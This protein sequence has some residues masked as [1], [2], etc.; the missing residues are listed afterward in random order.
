M[1]EGGLYEFHK[2]LGGTL[3]SFLKILIHMHILLLAIHLD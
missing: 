2:Y 1:H 3:N